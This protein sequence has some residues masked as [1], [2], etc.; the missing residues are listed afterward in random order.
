MHIVRLESCQLESERHEARIKDAQITRDV[1][2]DTIL[3]VFLGLFLGLF[4][5]KLRYLSVK[6]FLCYCACG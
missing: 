1:S 2:T 5:D 3:S 6:V 4:K